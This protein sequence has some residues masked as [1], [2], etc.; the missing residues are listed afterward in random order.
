M[1]ASSTTIPLLSWSS[2]SVA[3]FIIFQLQKSL[4]DNRLPYAVRPLLV[5]VGDYLFPYRLIELHFQPAQRQR[6]WLAP[7]VP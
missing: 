2:S 5:G 3:L 7:M 1:I 4:N 6:K